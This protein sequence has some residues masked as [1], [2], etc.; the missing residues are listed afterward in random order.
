MVSG[1]WLV[2]EIWLDPPEPVGQEIQLDA[3][4]AAV[5]PCE[6]SFLN[7]VEPFAYITVH[8]IDAPSNSQLFLQ[9]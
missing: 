7:C 9:F 8:C 6:G 3:S 2:I 1:R 4:K 5:F